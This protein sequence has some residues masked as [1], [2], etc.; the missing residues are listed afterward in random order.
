MYVHCST[1]VYVQQSLVQM[2]APIFFIEHEHLNKVAGLY[3]VANDYWSGN[4][5]IN[6][7]IPFKTLLERLSLLINFDL[8]FNRFFTISQSFNFILIG[9]VTLL[10][11]FIFLILYLFRLMSRV[12]ELSFFLYFLVIT[13]LLILT[14]INFCLIYF[15]LVLNP[16]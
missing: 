6:E 4:L 12:Y 2:D 14:I 11:L 13:K 15:R 10:Y 1:H 5:F 9:F 7:L 8:Q 16:L 3:L